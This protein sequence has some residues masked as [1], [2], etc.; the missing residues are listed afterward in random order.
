MARQ[1]VVGFKPF[2]PARPENVEFRRSQRRIVEGYDRKI[3][4]L[5]LVS[6]AYLKRGAALPAEGAPAETRRFDPANVLFAFA[7]V[8]IIGWH[9]CEGDRRRSSK[10]LAR[11]AMAP[12]AV[13]RVA[14]QLVAH[15]STHA[16]ARQAHEISSFVD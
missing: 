7:P 1:R 12:A 6:H 10:Q 2:D 14:R 8:E 5:R 16:S 15:R 3:D 11:P 9:A 13:E 4:R